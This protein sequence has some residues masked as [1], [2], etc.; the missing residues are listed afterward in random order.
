MIVYYTKPIQKLGASS[1]QEFYKED[2]IVTNE[3]CDVLLL[4]LIHSCLE[5]EQQY[6]IINIMKNVLDNRHNKA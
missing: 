6:S 4:L 1:D 2:F 3:L 5:F